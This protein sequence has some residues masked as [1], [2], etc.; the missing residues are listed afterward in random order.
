MPKGNEAEKK[1]KGGSFYQVPVTVIVLL[2]VVMPVTLEDTERVM[3]AATDCPEVSCVP[4]WFQVM[5][6]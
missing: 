3:V 4:P 1:G 2:N 5:V 6:M